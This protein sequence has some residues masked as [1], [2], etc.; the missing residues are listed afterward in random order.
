MEPTTQSPPATP[1]DQAESR[2]KPLPATE[3]DFHTRPSRTDS[4]GFRIAVIIAVVVLLVVGFFVYRYVTSYESTDDAEVDGHINSISA[5]ISG[6]VVKLNVLD[7][8][9]VQ[10]GTVLVEID[11]ADY[12]VAYERAKADFDDAQAAAA[13][14]GVNVPITSVNTTS[15]VS[16]TEADVA[17]ARAGIAAAR[18]Q[19]E[20]AKAQLAQARAND[21]KAQNDLGRYKQLVDK[22]EI[23]N[24]QYDEAVA[25]SK[26]SAATVDAA[27]ATADAAQSQV[28]QAQGK[29]VQAEANLSSARTAPRQMEVIRSRAA[30]ALAEAQLKKAEFD[31]AQLNLLYTRITAPVTGVVSDRTVEVGQNVAPGQELMKVIPL[32]DVWITADFKETQLREMKVGQPVTIEVD[33]NGRKYKGKVDSIAGASGARFSL[34][35]PENATGNYV[36]VVQRIPVKIVLDPGENN[37]QSLRPG[38]SVEPKV[39]TRQ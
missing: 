32:N 37:D 6:H 4:P 5:R 8:Q 3:R 13:G 25:A 33:A 1:P 30:S 19:F 29:L 15:Q 22:Q 26:A 16:A 7:N 18:Q 9:Y 11:P 38:M 2:T 10:A 23:S 20:A 31:Q 39:W 21:V 28:T 12:Q 35:P 36:K 27:S 14:A 34:L 17:S 24:Q